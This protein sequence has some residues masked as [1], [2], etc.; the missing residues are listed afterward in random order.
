LCSSTSLETERFKTLPDCSDEAM[1]L[2]V[3]ELNWLLNG[4]DLRRNRQHQ[5]LTP[6]FF[7]CFGTIQGMI[8]MP[9][10][11][12]VDPVLLKQQLEQMLPLPADLPRIEVIHE[13][14]K[15]ELTCT[16]GWLHFLRFDKLASSVGARISR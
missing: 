4:F 5:V 14:P 7:A 15:H 9:K 3:Q 1:V 2:T 10:D 16:C 6:R 12:P 11:L 8:S 13:P